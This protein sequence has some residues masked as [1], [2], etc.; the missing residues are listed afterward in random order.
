M[1]EKN[2]TP[3]GGAATQGSEGQKKAGGLIS[4]IV[5]VLVA[6]LLVAI[7]FS[8]V[9][10]FVLKTDTFGLG[11]R[12]RSDLQKNPI[13]RLALPT[14]PEDFDADAPENLSE[15]EL[16]VK[17]DQY[18]QIAQDLQE[19]LDAANMTISAITAE[20]VSLAAIEANNL[21]AADQNAQE[22]LSIE[23]Q[24]AE[25]E[26]L[27]LEIAAAA[28][29]GDTAGFKQYFEKLDPTVSAEI[30][31][32]IIS[33]EKTAE[34]AKLA[35]RPFELMDRQKAADVLKELWTKDQELLIDIVDANKSQTLAEIMA[36]M[37]ASLAADITQRLADYRKARVNTDTLTNP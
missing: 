21:G 18:R 27:S 33:S 5:A 23:K 36:N 22:A 32:S 14:I 9:F 31:K 17:Y 12:F 30:Y 3:K 7:V 8:G 4:G 19:Q 34:M 15:K 2:T 25:L 20:N 29:K 6:L 26:A 11:E 16:L 24:K 28:A 10:F 13:L 37:E 1:S 35:A